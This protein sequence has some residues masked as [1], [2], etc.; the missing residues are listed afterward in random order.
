MVFIYVM[1]VNPIHIDFRRVAES[2]KIIEA[3][4]TVGTFKNN[5]NPL[6]RISKPSNTFT[7]HPNIH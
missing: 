3:V 5:K 2:I 4:Q 6:V 1:S 7:G